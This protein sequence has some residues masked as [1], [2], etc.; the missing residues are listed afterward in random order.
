[1]QAKS[2]K[3]KVIVATDTIGPESGNKSISPEL[4]NN[5]QL[6]EKRAPEEISYTIEKVKIEGEVKIPGKSFVIVKF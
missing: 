1:M 4:M 5:R 3:A 2:G 6:C